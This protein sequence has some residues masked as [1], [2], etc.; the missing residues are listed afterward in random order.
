[1][2]DEAIALIITIAIIALLFAWVPLLNWVCPP[3]GRFLERCRYQKEAYKD[4]YRINARFEIKRI[5]PI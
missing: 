2:S 4:P 5:P 3:C 1:M